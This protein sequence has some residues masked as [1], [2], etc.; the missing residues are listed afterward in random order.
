MQNNQSGQQQQN[1]QQQGPNS[2]QQNAQQNAQQ[3]GGQ[4]Q[5]TGVGFQAIHDQARQLFRQYNFEKEEAAKLGHTT[6]EGKAH[7]L[8]AEKIKAI[9][10]TYTRRQKL[11]QQQQQ[12]KQA[13]AQAQAQAQ[14]Q[15]QNA[16]AMPNQNPVQL[17]APLAQPSPVLAANANSNSSLNTMNTVNSN[18][19]TNLVANVNSSTPSQ[20]TPQAHEGR[21]LSQQMNTNDSNTTPKSTNFDSSMVT[22]TPAQ[23]LQLKRQQLLTKYQQ[24]I[25]MSEQFKKNMALI[26]KRLSEPNIDE[27]TRKHLLEKEHEVKTRLENCKNCT[28]QIAT[29]LKIAQQ[30]AQQIAQQNRI[31]AGSPLQQLQQVPSQSSI[32]SV[33]SSQTG[34]PAAINS[35]GSFVATGST[36]VATSALGASVANTASNMK[37]NGDSLTAGSPSSAATSTG[38]GGKGKANDASAKAAPKKAAPKKNSKTDAKRSASTA[39]PEGAN[40]K[41]K[42]VASAAVSNDTGAATGGEAKNGKSDSV[43][44]V[45]G[46]TSSTDINDSAKFQNMNIPDDLNVKTQNP[47]SVKVNNRPSILGG[48]AVNAP[49]LTNPVM[50]KPQQFEIEGERVLNKR[51]LKELVASVANEEGE[52]EINIDGDVEE[53]LLDLADEFVTSV[54]S[55]ASRLAR[56]RHSDNLDVRDV[57]LHLERNWNIRIPGYA[58][59]EIRMIRKFVPNSMHDAKLDGVFINKSVDKAP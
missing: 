2:N 18:S 38:K 59:D 14:N 16:T 1:L 10:V 53:L 29:Q 41:Q 45:A 31:N 19:N 13:Q 21:T 8:K 11:L 32:P 6:P 56:H 26:Q 5:Q 7:M 37:L 40:K 28:Q 15:A 30:Q 20:M 47:A 51:K 33:G 46:T 50:V 35:A 4:G 49:A 22:L 58:A 17:Q 12:Q 54:T 42:V 39:E 25:T 55:F 9:L 48:N 44:P 27:N 36:P 34:T 3:N 52:T 57:Q 43:Q 24:I 23:Q